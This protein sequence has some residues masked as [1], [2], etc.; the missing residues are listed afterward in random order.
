MKKFIIIGAKAALTYQEVF[1]LLKERK[2]WVGRTNP[3][4]FYTITGI[5]N[6]MCGL[7]RWFSNVGEPKVK[8]IKHRS[9]YQEEYSKIDNFPAIEVGKVR[10]IPEG[11]EGLMAVPITFLEWF[12]PG[13]EIIGLLK[14]DYTKLD[15]CI[16]G[17]T[18]VVEGV[19]KFTRVVIRD[20]KNV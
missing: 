7:T 13:Y 11:Y 4:E 1:P 2:I 15:D 16:I 10:D 12:V 18:P 19:K 8:D 6:N 14:G 5:T 3:G 20:A 9:R 17:H